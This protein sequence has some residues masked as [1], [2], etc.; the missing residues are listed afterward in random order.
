M[1]KG[2]V[3]RDL[4]RTFKALS[5]KPRLEI[6][7]LMF[8][9]GALCGCEVERFLGLS[10]SAASR[11]LRTLREAGLVEDRRDGQWVFY[12][13]PASP[14]PFAV[15][16]L[17]LLRGWLAEM[18]LPEIGPELVSIRGSRREA[19]LEPAPS[20]AEGSR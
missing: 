2:P 3:V 6:L 8:R 14:D 20:G 9:H 10:Q 12:G 5:E 4:T 1:A 11:H 7:A 16:L 17:G 18:R 19:T 15:A 13:P